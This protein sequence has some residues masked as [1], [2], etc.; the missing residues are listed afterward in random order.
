M[1]TRPGDQFVIRRR[2]LA[3][4]KSEFDSAGVKFAFPTVQIASGAEA[5]QAAAAAAHQA[6]NGS[7]TADEHG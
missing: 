5:A 1:M 4:I 7:K 3:M 6:I 2:A